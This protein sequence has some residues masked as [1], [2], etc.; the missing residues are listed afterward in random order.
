MRIKSL[1]FI[2]GNAAK[3]EQ[4]SRH[5]DFSVQ[6]RKIHLPEIQ[7]L[8]LEEIVAYK[9]HE[10]YK[11]TNTPVLVEDSSLIFAAMG[12][13]PGPLIKWFLE[14]LEEDGLCKLL[15]CYET[16]EAVARVLFGY[17]DGKSLELFDG[18]MHGTIADTPRGNAGFGWDPIFIPKG[19]TKTWGEMDT[20]KQK[21]T[22][23]RRIALKKLESFLKKNS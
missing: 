7:S 8:S 18:S 2:T 14:S 1:T 23:M 6:H 12:K 22:S 21:E 9:A 17:Y 20:E 16:R 5:L 13:L 3:A 11:L 4:L 10:A 19:H 15:D